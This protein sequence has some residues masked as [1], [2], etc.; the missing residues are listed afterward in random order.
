MI[1]IQMVSRVDL[2]NKYWHR[3][4][5]LSDIYKLHIQYYYYII[6]ATISTL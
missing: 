6:I 1:I 4:V 5:D 2:V 3:G